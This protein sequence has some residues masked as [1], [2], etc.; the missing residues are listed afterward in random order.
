[1]D[2]CD[3][4]L[5]KG[6]AAVRSLIA[7]RRPLFEFAIDSTLAKYDLATL[8]GRVLAMRAIAPIIA[9]I[10]DRDLRPAYMRKVSGQ[11]GLEL[12]EIQRAVAYAQNHPKLSRSQQAEATAAAPR[13]ERLNEGPQ[14][15]SGTPG[16]AG[17][18][19]YVGAPGYAGAQGAVHADAPY[20]PAYD[21]P[22]PEDHAAPSA[23]AGQNAA[24]HPPSSIQPAAPQPE[25]TAP[26]VEEFLTPDPRDPVARLE[27]ARSR[28]PCSTPSSSVWNS[29]VTS[30]PCSSAT[31]PTVRWPPAF[32][33][34]ATVM[35]PTPGIEW[36]KLRA[37]RRCGGRTSRHRGARRL[38][39]TGQQ[40]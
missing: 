6:D 4:R 33:H 13:Y 32:I 11:L 35:A 12:D 22:P 10:K 34:A 8:E 36:I 27:K 31:A 3:L 7:S 25:V 29:G 9:G 5:H 21:A 2:P 38:T 23:Y 40:R 39:A 28:L 16:Y 20:D 14:G 19:G 18:Q 30:P 17:A 24:A 26:A 37:L 15:V 1:M